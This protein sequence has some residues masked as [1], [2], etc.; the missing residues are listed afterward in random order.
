MLEPVVAFTDRRLEW[1]NGEAAEAAAD[2]ATLT[3]TPIPG[4]DFWSRTFY[5]PAPLVKSDGAALLAP[6]PADEEATLSVGFTLGAQG[7]FDQAGAFVWCDDDTFVKCGIEF[8]DKVPRLSVVVT[9]GGYSD[10]STQL[11]PFLA[12]RLRVTKLAPGEAQGPALLVEAAP[13]EKG[14]TADSPGDWQFV[15]VAPV[16]A[17]GKPWRMGVYAA[18]HTEQKPSAFH[19][20]HIG[21]KRELCHKQQI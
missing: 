2:G 16:R 7:Q 13:Y 6:I 8:C 19:Y 5:G 20:I 9:N 18:S 21:P 1:L 4:R 14:D 11:L 17:V 15:R 3:I 10:W 12:L